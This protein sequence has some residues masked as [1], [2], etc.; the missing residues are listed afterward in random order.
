MYKFTEFLIDE[1]PSL[2]RANIKVKFSLQPA[3]RLYHPRRSPFIFFRYFKHS[4][5]I[6]NLFL[7]A[8]NFKFTVQETL[9][10][11]NFHV[12]GMINGW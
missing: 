6:N 5:K 7:L 8:G 12:A 10:Q 3:T 9:S 4:R 2:N 11:S 1:I